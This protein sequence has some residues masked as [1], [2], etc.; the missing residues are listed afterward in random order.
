MN[1]LGLGIANPPPHTLQ[2]YLR[3]VFWCSA[4]TAQFEQ[5]FAC[6]VEHENLL[7]VKN[8]NTC[9]LGNIQ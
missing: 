6:I 7:E 3:T 9:F 1:E 5:V 4:F 8:T 2:Q